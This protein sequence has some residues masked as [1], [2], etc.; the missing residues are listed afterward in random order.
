[1]TLSVPDPNH[2]SSFLNIRVADIQA[3][4]ELWKSRGAEFIT[5]RSPS[6][7]RSATTSAVRRLHDR[8]RTEHPAVSPPVNAR[9]RSEYSSSEACWRPAGTDLV[10]GLVGFAVDSW[11]PFPSRNPLIEASANRGPAISR[12]DLV[13]MRSKPR[14]SYFEPVDSISW[15]SGL[16]PGRLHHLPPL[17]WPV[18]RRKHRPKF[19]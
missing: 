2:I 17:P 6:T 11:S 5:S 4:Y 14:I 15:C 19:V 18:R 12:I 8:G 1:M 10:Y 16:I 9:P 13:S 3:C 7:A